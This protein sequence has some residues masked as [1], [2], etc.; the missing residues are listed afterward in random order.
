MRSTDTKP[1]TRPTRRAAGRPAPPAPEVFIDTSRMSH[2]QRTALETAEAARAGADSRAS[3]AGRLLLG[4]FAWSEIDPFPESSDEDRRIGDRLVAGVTEILSTQ[5][6]AEEV[7][8]TRTIPPA[9]IDALQTLG[10]FRMKVPAEY[11]GLGLSQVNYNRVVQ[12]IA[13]Y[14]G[15][16]AVLVSAHQSIGVPQPLKIFGTPEQK[17]TYL[18]RISA[19]ALSAFALTESGVGSDPAQM[20]T[21]ATPIENGAAYLLNGEKLWTTNGPVAELLV[22]MAQTPPRIVRG[23]EKRQITA[24]LVEANAKGVEVAHRCDFMGLRAIQNGVLTFHNVRVPAENVLWGEGLGLKLALHTLNTGRLTLPAACA[25]MAKQCLR[26]AREWGGARV[27]W[28]HAVGRHEAGRQKIA[29]IAATT[30]AMEAVTWLTSHWA[31]AGR[32]I[33]IEA[34]LAKLFC[35]EAA[36]RLVDETLQLRG[37]RGYERAD[38]L[39]ARGETPYP[40]ERMMRDCRINTIIEGTSEIMRLFLAREALDPHLRIASDLLRPGLPAARK[41]RCGMRVLG[42]YGHWYPR[43]LVGRTWG[44]GR[45]AGRLAPHLRF[46]DRNTHRLAGTLFQAMARHQQKLERKQ[47]TLGALMDNAAELFAMA[48]TCAYARHLDG[49]DRDATALADLF[50]RQTRRRIADGFRRARAR[51]QN[52]E[53][54]MAGRVLDGG[55]RWLEE[56]IIPAVPTTPAEGA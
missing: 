16:T 41:L 40:V 3:F 12:A 11:G 29:D 20:R 9:V 7:D 21:T 42:F 19:G 47:V 22:V 36:W 49:D 35:S 25:G 38:S 45:G 15:S 10:V 55:F 23:R 24:F 51:G 31:D 4:D 27:Q 8:R 50:C 44:R 13:S 46:I 56:G 53:N 17:A 33:R 54:K 6:D 18:P 39:A 43:Q 5:L 30:L 52:H 14:C 48:A 34:G 37:G 1:P 2:G 26:I 32:D 28:G